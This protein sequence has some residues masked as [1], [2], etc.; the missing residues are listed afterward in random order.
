MDDNPEQSRTAVDDLDVPQD[1]A[2][3]LDQSAE[4]LRHGRVE[5]ARVALA[6]LQY[7]LD[8]HLARKQAAPAKG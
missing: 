4:D 5:D 2:S 3:A 8:D 6:R 7:R 1:L